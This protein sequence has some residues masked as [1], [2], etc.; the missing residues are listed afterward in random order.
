MP[1]YRLLF[2]W[3]LALTFTS[4]FSSCSVVVCSPNFLMQLNL[5]IKSLYWIYSEKC[6][7]HKPLSMWSIV[8]V[9]QTCRANQQ[10][11][12]Y[13]YMWLFVLIVHLMI[14]FLKADSGCIISKTIWYLTSVNVIL[15][16][17]HEWNPQCFY[18]A[19]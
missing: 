17:I 14:Y 11:W 3:W 5:K 15:L 4:T 2:E 1:D 16:M 6:E 10:A 9:F 12:I 13:E 19:M 8:T 7:L 18:R